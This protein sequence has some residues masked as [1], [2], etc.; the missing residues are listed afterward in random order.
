MPIALYNIKMMKFRSARHTNKLKPLICF[1]HDLLG[2][3]ILG[4]FMGHDGYNGVFLGPVNADWHLEF[5]ES[6]EKAT[7]QPD[8]DDLLVF[9]CTLPQYNEIITK[10][11]AHNIPEIYPKNP[12]WALNGKAYRDPDGFSIVLT[13]KED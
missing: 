13:V 4:E 12:Y 7:H 5:T 8:D 1:Y 10:L 2:L 6:D 11:A 9:Y 3:P